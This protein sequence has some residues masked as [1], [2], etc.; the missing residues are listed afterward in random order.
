MISWFFRALL[1][2]SAGGVFVIANI[3]SAM[4][5]FGSNDDLVNHA[6]AFAVLTLLV[7]AAFPSAR[8][9]RVFLGL[10]L[11][12]LVIELSQRAL[13]LGR[14]AELRDWLA[15]A[16]AAALVLMLLA[17]LRAIRRVFA[18]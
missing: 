10:M 11:V 16:A 12:N 17:M 9:H 3:P 6:A 7:V 4:V 2:G 8:P 1:V 13:G 15:G 5:P 14:Q 18:A